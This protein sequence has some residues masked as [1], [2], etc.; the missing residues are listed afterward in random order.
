MIFSNEEKHLLIALK[1]HSL[2]ERI[3][4]FLDKNEYISGQ[5]TWKMFDRVSRDIYC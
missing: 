4:I 5:E 2:I 3:R 1:T